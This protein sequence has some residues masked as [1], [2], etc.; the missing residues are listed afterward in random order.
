[1]HFAVKGMVKEAEDIVE[2]MMQRNIAPNTVTFNVLIDGYNLV[3]QIDKARKLLDSMTGR[4]LK[5]S[6]ISYNNLINGYCKKGKVEELGAFS[7]KFLGKELRG[8]CAKLPLPFLIAISIDQAIIAN[9]RSDIWLVTA[10][11][12]A[13]EDSKSKVYSI[14]KAIAIDRGS[15]RMLVD[16]DTQ[17]THFVKYINGNTVLFHLDYTTQQFG[18][19]NNRRLWAQSEHLTKQENNIIYFM[20]RTE[21]YYGL[22]RKVPIFAAEVMKR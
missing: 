14:E 17:L 5:P 18:E 11:E 15:H 21:I 19:L 12:E 3:G 2:V 4:G 13:A 6:I 10:L 20:N 9:D 7:S 16:R 1:M 8:K 22:W